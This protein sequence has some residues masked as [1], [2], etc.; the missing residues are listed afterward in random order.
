MAH[1][2]LEHVL[3]SPPEQKWTFFDA[4]FGDPVAWPMPKLFTIQ[5]GDLTHDVY[6]TKFMVLELIAAALVLIIYI[7]L[8]RRIASGALPKGPFWNF[9][10]SLLTFVR[11]EIAKPNLQ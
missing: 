11:N 4:L 5:L 6:L 8:A 10:E 1:D 2:P 3:D 9:F 7:P